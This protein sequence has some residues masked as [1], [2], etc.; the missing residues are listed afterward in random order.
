MKLNW[1]HA[2]DK[3]IDNGIKFGG[4]ALFGQNKNWRG[5]FFYV[6]GGTLVTTILHFAQPSQLWIDPVFANNPLIL[7]LTVCSAYALGELINSFV[8]RRLRIAPGSQ[9]NWVQR[10]IDSIDGSIATGIVLQFGF[11]VPLDLLL[12]ALAISLV[13]H[14]STDVW[15]RKLGLKSK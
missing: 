3:P 6:F 4:A 1:L 12:T 7:G 10:F 15:M 13:I 14:A 9:G 5:V 11:N 8:K 2:L